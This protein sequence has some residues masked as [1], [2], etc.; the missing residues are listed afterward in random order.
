MVTMRW[1]PSERESARG[2]SHEAWLRTLITPNPDAR[3]LSGNP[4]HPIPSIQAISPQ[5][6]RRSA[7]PR[8][9]SKAVFKGNLDKF[10]VY[11]QLL[12]FPSYSLIGLQT[13]NHIITSCNM[14]SRTPT[15]LVWGSFRPEFTQENV[16]NVGMSLFALPL[17]LLT[18]QCC[19]NQTRITSPPKPSS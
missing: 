9:H 5:R 18:T 12:L 15:R 1:N 7:P 6:L 3:A 16:E 11:C 8:T 19:I 17:S 13:A 10:T 4:V 14:A 2:G